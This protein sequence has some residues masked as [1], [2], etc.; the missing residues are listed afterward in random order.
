MDF[1]RQLDI[2]VIVA[3]ALLVFVGCVFFGGLPVKFAA[4]VAGSVF[5]MGLLFGREVIEGIRGNFL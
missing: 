1:Y 3:S 2:F 5:L 4:I